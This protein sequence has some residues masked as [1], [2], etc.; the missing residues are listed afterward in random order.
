ME[1]D[2]GR[3]I[4][5]LVSGLVVFLFAMNYLSDNLKAL[6][7]D[8]MQGF[9]DKFT[10]NLVTGILSGTV[11][12]VLLD[13]SSAVI[14]MTIALVNA[15]ALTFQQAMGIVLGANIGTTI[16]SQLIAFDIGQYAAI[17]MVVG[18]IVSVA[19]RSEPVRISGKILLGMG[20]L[21]FGLFTIEESVKPL[22]DSGT[23]RA[24]MLQLENPLGGAAVGAL[25]TFIVQSSSA[26]VGM[27]IGLGAQKLIT[28]AAAI[29][30]MLGAEL[31]TCSDTLI[32]CAGRS[33]Q[34]VKTGIFHLLFNIASITL[35]LLLIHPFTEL[36]LLV[37]RQ[38][39]LPRQIA[40]AHVLFNC[41]GVLVFAPIAPHL[42]P[43]LN[44]L[45]NVFSKT[46]DGASA[47][48]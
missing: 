22:R 38:A 15:R 26:T 27:V 14:I 44:R 7:G 41:L 1:M 10:R 4:L 42:E 48:V 32:A 47:P 46:T 9:L 6:S 40:N 8:R 37:S 35:G 12:T 30:V 16:S 2:Y 36:V 5:T 25:V 39:A 3:I 34:A 23:F 13:S 28:L 31:G 45:V 21:F 18:L 43:L 33:K 29:A 17:P 20:L 11:V 19:G 24:W